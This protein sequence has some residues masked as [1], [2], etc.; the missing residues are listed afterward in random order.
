MNS[1][2]DSFEVFYCKLLCQYTYGIMVVKDWI[3]FVYKTS[4][5][6]CSTKCL[7]NSKAFSRSFGNCVSCTAAL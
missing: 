6:A 4:A 1:P 2:S 3:Y 5:L 7:P